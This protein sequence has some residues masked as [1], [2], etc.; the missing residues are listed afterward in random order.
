MW[1][2]WTKNGKNING[3]RGEDIVDIASNGR[4]VEWMQP[5]ELR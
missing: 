2:D 4:S 1:N 3:A 5:E